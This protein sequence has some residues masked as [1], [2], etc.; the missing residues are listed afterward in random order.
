VAGAVGTAIALSALGGALGLGAQEVDR[1]PGVSL[2]LV[3][4]SSYLPALAIQPFSGTFGGEG[5]APQVEA[6]VGR[7]LENADRFQMM[8][9][10][11][12][13][14]VGD[15]VDYALWDR[16][17]AVWLVTGQL[18]G[19]GDGFVLVLELHDVVYREVKERG[20]FRVPRPAEGDFRMAVHGASD[21][22][23]RWV[24]GEPGM[25][26]SRIVFTMEDGATAD[27]AAVKNVYM[28]DSDGE[29]LERLTNDST[30]AQSAAWSPDGTKIAYGS[31]KSGNQRIYELDLTTRRERM[32]ETVRGA[33][34]YITPAYHPDGRTLAFSVLG[35]DMRSGIFTYDVGRDCCLAYLSG[36][37]W[38]DISPTY[39]PDGR[40]MAF[41]TLRFGDHVPQVMVMPAEGGSAETLSPYE[42]GGGGYFT[43]PDWSP[44]GDLVAF[45][46]RIERGRYHI[47]VA[48]LEQGGRVL[49][50]LTSE[51]NNEDPSWAP[52]GRHLVFVG[53]R[54]WGYGLFVVDA[55]SG[56]IRSLMSGRRIQVPDWSPA[57][58]PR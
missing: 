31:V 24:T 43:S 57:L 3:Y 20:R 22:I 25:A 35:S 15:Q 58:Q 49:R 26:A 19:A 41:N 4:A 46:G 18:E 38:Y 55:T 30:V 10:L 12:S 16:L 1:I 14:F 48:S 37:P 39:S 23:V 45:H 40:W 13:G 11:P 5:T 36:G 42:Y 54:S 29:N 33:G 7:D 50:Q 6:I 53:E 51:G 27:G 8:H 32:L 47:L 9:D 2:G 17:G 56:R 28:I 34:D 21:E 52:D 44:T